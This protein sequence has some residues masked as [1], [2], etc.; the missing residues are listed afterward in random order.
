MSKGTISGELSGYA[1]KLSADGR[2]ASAPPSHAHPYLCT[3]PLATGSTPLLPLRY[4]PHCRL[5][6]P[7]ENQAKVGL[8]TVLCGFIPVAGVEVLR[9]RAQCVLHYHGVIPLLPSVQ[10]L[11]NPTPYVLGCRD[12]VGP[13]E[14][15]R[16]KD[17]ETLGVPSPVTHSPQL[18][19]QGVHVSPPHLPARRFVA[20]R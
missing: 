6:F 20:L 4:P 17:N 5:E 14:R 11:L 9:A 7:A 16:L 12:M 3:F 13:L 18:L 15:H 19:H 1:S 8:S 2:R 10:S